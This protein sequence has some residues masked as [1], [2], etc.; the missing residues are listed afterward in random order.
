M[1]TRLSGRFAHV[2]RSRAHGSSFH[3]STPLRGAIAGAIDPEQGGNVALRGPGRAPPNRSARASTSASRAPALICGTF[4]TG[5]ML[6]LAPKPWPGSS[7]HSPELSST[8]VQPLCYSKRS[9]TLPLLMKRTRTRLGVPMMVVL[10]LGRSG[11][12]TRAQRQTYTLSASEFAPRLQ[13][14]FQGGKATP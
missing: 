1:K 2:T 11:L 9:P 4:T 3:S 10:A 5:S 12:P 7:G 14:E 6:A 8:L 13:S